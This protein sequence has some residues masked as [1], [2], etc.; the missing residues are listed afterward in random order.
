MNGETNI[1][2]ITG[3][4]T[5]TVWTSDLEV[6]SHHGSNRETNVP[7]LMRETSVSA[8]SHPF[9][10]DTADLLTAHNIQQDWSEH[11]IRTA[12]LDVQETSK[13][14]NAIIQVASPA[15]N[16]FDPTL[17]YINGDISADFNYN[18]P[19]Y[20]DS[21]Q[22][23]LA[24]PVVQIDWNTLASSALAPSIRQ[25][26]PTTST[27]LQVVNL[28]TY[29][30]P[31]IPI[32]AGILRTY[33]KM[34]LRKTTL[35][36]FIHI[37]ACGQPDSDKESF[38]EPLAICMS[39][40]HMFA[41]QTNESKTFLHRTIEAERR[42]F[43]NSKLAGR[44]HELCPGPFST[45]DVEGS[46]LTWEDWIFSETRR[47]IACVCFLISLINFGASVAM[48]E[49][50]DI[51][52]PS[53][54]ALWAACS[55]S[56]WENEY[57]ISRAKHKPLTGSR[58]ENLEALCNAQNET[59]SGVSDHVRGLDEWNLGLDELGMLITMALTTV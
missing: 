45:K 8:A 18:Y 34:M 40:A 20:G 4:S 36:P 31:I 2:L 15:G 43:S 25:S 12:F 27:S 47:R 32:I 48:K 35:P 10:Q 44:F 23:F 16:Q 39:I 22:E 56:T 9:Y 30:S 3:T 57:D 59:K 42:R 54:K 46:R 33:P 21:Q 41:A 13:P 14:S 53:N 5:S 49:F 37:L 7:L 38:P 50:H 26:H 51:P 1:E 52:L 55:R 58:L 29:R 19:N 17:E 6:A 28:P 24:E 11:D